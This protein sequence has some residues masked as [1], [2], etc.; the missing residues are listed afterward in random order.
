MDSLHQNALFIFRRDLRLEDNT[1]LINALEESKQ[2]LPCFILDPRLL[3]QPSPHKNATQFMFEALHDLDNSLQ[4]KQ[5]HLNFFEGIPEDILPKLIASYNLD[6][7]YINRDYSPFS[8]RRD[9]RIQKICED[10]KIAFKQFAD[11]LLNE[12]ETITTKNNEPYK[13]FTPF[14]RKAFGIP[15]STPKKNTYTNYSLIQQNQQKKRTP[16]LPVKKR[17]SANTL[18]GPGTRKACLDILDNLHTF[19]Q[20]EISRD[21]PSQHGTTRLS[22][23]IKFGLCSIREV[24]TAITNQLKPNHLLLKQL[25]WRDFYTHIAYHYPHVFTGAFRRR[26]NDIHWNADKILFETWCQGKT[27]FPIVDAGMQELNT[28]GW[29][30]NRVRMIVASFLTK[31]LHINWQWGERYFAS[32]LIDYDPAVNNGN[33]QWTASTG[34]DA[35]PF[36][37]IFNPWRQQ[38]KY[39]PDCTYIKQWIPALADIEPVIIHSWYK[40]TEFDT[41]I[42]YPKPIVD[43]KQESQYSK[44]LFKSTF[45]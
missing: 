35:Q 8:Q 30:H 31:D 25:Y 27:G 3:H 12:P 13:V 20:Y 42:K 4:R 41:Q 5:S 16:T 7:V 29:M 28:T 9:A 19:K 15:I 37:R 17:K 45:S 21:I 24:F 33:W 11:A 40:S 6:A 14:F 36:F 26:F 2:V 34:V 43:H 1:G 18:V 38:E 39:D 10:T 32:K 23:Y 44:E 22:A